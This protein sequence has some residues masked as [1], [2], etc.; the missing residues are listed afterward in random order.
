MSAKF[1]ILKQR[2]SENLHLNLSGDFNDMSVCELIDVLRDNCH[3]VM[4][5]FIHTKNLDKVSTSNIGRDVFYKNLNIM[6]DDSFQIQFT[7]GYD[8]KLF[9][10]QIHV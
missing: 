8:N 9:P 3:S 1:K 7:G 2:Q 6:N 4:R 5:V 10:K